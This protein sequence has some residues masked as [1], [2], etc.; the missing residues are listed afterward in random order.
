MKTRTSGDN[1]KAKLIKAR[2]IEKEKRRYGDPEDKN[3]ELGKSSED[4]WKGREQRM[5]WGEAFCV[6]QSEWTGSD[7][8]WRM[9]EKAHRDAQK[10]WLAKGVST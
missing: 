3:R 6:P 9:M 10:S 4:V 1:E 8:E 5:N 2:W 7:E